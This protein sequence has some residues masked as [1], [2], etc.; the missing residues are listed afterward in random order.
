MVMRRPVVV[1]ELAGSLRV[2][3]LAAH[4]SA[5]S[6]TRRRLEGIAESGGERLLEGGAIQNDAEVA[7]FEDSVALVVEQRTGDRDGIVDARAEVQVDLA[8]EREVEQG[9]GR[10]PSGDSP[11]FADDARNVMVRQDVVGPLAW[12]RD[13]K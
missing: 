7:A 5:A 10:D 3:A 1:S 4:R 11:P 6:R 12:G 9:E 2:D 8:S 13:C